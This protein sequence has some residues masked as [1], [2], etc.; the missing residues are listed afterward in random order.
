MDVEAVVGW[1]VARLRAK[2]RLS[3]GDL[4]S[5][6]ALIDQSYIS[7]LEAGK[8]NP[9]AVMLTLISNA[10][11]V[12]VGE[13]FAIKGVPDK[14]VEGPVRIRSSRSGRRAI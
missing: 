3:Q 5:Q 14:V 6:V 10:L 8:L 1:N 2:L 9:T 11:D 4:A 7:R 12:Q 13:L